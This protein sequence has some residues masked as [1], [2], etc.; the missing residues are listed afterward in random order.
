MK[1]FFEIRQDGHAT[2]VFSEEQESLACDVF[3]SVKEQCRTAKL[4]RRRVDEMGK[5]K[6]THTYVH[7]KR[8]WWIK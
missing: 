5:L 8:G 4:Q 7:A 3:K 6:M 1:K 2:H